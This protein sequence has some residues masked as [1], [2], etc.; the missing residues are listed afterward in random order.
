MK[1]NESILSGKSGKNPYSERNLPLIPEEATGT[2]H[3]T[4]P[5]NTAA[6]LLPSINGGRVENAGFSLEPPGINGSQDD[7]I[8][9]DHLE[10]NPQITAS[11]ELPSIVKEDDEK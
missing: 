1:A 10:S 2:G 7:M 6:S 3:V 4:D 9:M 11:A 8:I 5:R